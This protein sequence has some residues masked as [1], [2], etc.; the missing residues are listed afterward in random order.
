MIREV[1]AT[2]GQHRLIWTRSCYEFTSI[3]KGRA[4]FALFSR[5]SSTFCTSLAI[6]PLVWY[7][8]S[9]LR[10]FTWVASLLLFVL[11]FFDVH[12][13]SW[14]L[15]TP[16]ST[17]FYVLVIAVA[18]VW[19][20]LLVFWLLHLR[21]LFEMKWFYTNKL[22]ISEQEVSTIKW[23]NVVDRLVNLPGL[24]RTGELTH[25][26]V[27]QRIMRRDNYMIAL[28]NR[29]ILALHLPCFAHSR[30]VTKSLE[31]GLSLSLFQVL[32]RGSN[33]SESYQEALH[34][35][36][37]RSE[38]ANR[39]R[40]RFIL[41][42]VLS[43][44]LAPVI[45]LML[46]T[47]F[48]LRYG[49]ELR[50]KPNRLGLHCWSRYAH[51]K[52]REFNELPHDLEDR[53]NKAR[54]SASSYLDQ[55]TSP[56]AV[57]ICRFALFVC[58]SIVVGILVASFFYPDILDS[59][60]VLGRSGLWWLAVCGSALALF[61]A[62]LPEDHFVFQ[63]EHYFEEVSSHTHY[64]PDHWADCRSPVVVSQFNTLFPYQIQIL[65]LECVSVLVVPLIFIFSLPHC[66]TDIVRFI[67]ENTS[68]IAEVGDVCTFSDFDFAK[69]GNE[70]YG[71]VMSAPESSQ[72]CDGKME[73]SFVSFS[74][75]N[76]NWTPSQDG[77]ELMANLAQFQNSLHT[78]TPS[79]PASAFSSDKD[80]IDS[81]LQ[82][83]V[84][85][86]A[87]TQTCYKSRVPQ[88]HHSSGS[89]L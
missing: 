13:L 17:F 63:P 61:R 5:E 54:P 31:W 80:M 18:C 75:R 33:L 1:F 89:L 44:L 71:S 20:G 39:V 47:Y 10:S 38:V 68:T 85:S 87:K 74:S 55:F 26:H 25:L 40:R 41:V 81:L 65:L 46:I 19:G 27:A 83:S 42:G 9:L 45:F 21:V 7:S 88:P 84:A 59:D 62:F 2:C 30:I 34:N 43:L 51:W 28:V 77:Q 35:P 57:L 4:S 82:Q 12:T 78:D 32:F 36:L 66:A 22:E 69:H 53:L 56:Q 67:F 50:N 11:A 79:I 86:L 76:P 16:Q 15:Q 6:P 24:C 58:G 37:L 14:S 64:L 3:I 48:V 72:S 60:I 23:G 52:F 8:C 73:Q 49:E 70:M 29:D